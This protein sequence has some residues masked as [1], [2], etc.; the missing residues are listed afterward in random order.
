MIKLETFVRYKFIYDYLHNHILQPAAVDQTDQAFLELYISRFKPE[1][2]LNWASIYKCSEPPKIMR[3][4]YLKGLL[5][6]DKIA[7][8][9]WLY[10]PLKS[11]WS[12]K[13]STCA[14]DLMR[15]LGKVFEDDIPF[16]G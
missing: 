11:V 16:T 4:M 7:I 2:S 5:D 3:N 10:A 6:R 14:P 12:Y 13:L 1:F 8:N 15:G 9:P